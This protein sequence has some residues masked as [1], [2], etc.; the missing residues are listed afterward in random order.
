[1]TWG[2][3]IPVLLDLGFGVSSNAVA[4]PLKLD[5]QLSAIDRLPEKK[6]RPFFGARFLSAFGEIIINYCLEC[7]VGGNNAVAWTDNPKIVFEG[8]V[9]IRF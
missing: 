1:M 3:V 7:L 5:Q 6:V 9:D 2:Q 8:V 4:R